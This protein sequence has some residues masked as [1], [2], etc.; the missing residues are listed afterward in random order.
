[1]TAKLAEALSKAQAEMKAAPLNKINP[2]FKSK[3]ADLPAVIDA[4]RPALV[5]HGLSVTQTTQL[6]EGGGLKLVTTLH[7]ASGE[8]L[9]SEYPLPVGK[10][11][12]MGSALT[13]ARRYTLA[14]ICCIAADEDDDANAAESVGQKATVKPSPVKPATPAPVSGKPALIPVP[15]AADG[16]AADWLGWGGKLVATLKACTTPEQLSAWLAAN[17]QPLKNLRDTGPEKVAK[18]VDAVIA[19]CM[20]ATSQAPQEAA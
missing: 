18:R 20:A 13:Y 3:Y 5:K 11:Q 12:E 9:S 19:E 15:V 6:V 2:H 14:A 10:P 4:V 8:S 1:M 17:E 7:H 16:E